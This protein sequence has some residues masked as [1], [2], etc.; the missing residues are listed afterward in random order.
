[1]GLRADRPFASTQLAPEVQQIPDTVR[2]VLGKV[3][4]GMSSGRNAPP[5]IDEVR[6]FNQKAVAAH[7]E[8][9]KALVVETLPILN[10]TLAAAAGVP[11][12][13]SPAAQA[14]V[15]TALEAN[16]AADTAAGIPATVPTVTLETLSTVEYSILLAFCDA[17]PEVGVNT[18]TCQAAFFRK[19]V[20]HKVKTY[21]ETK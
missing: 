9:E 15:D 13:L 5:T 7:I 18:A 3:G 1:L 6:A 11:P 19:L 12:T 14:A 17:H 4:D 21:L 8:A 2:G 16:H 10:A 20:E